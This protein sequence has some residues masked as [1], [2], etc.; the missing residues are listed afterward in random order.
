M[1]DSIFKQ[2]SFLRSPFDVCFLTKI[3]VIFISGYIIGCKIHAINVKR[4]GVLGIGGQVQSIKIL[5]RKE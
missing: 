5:S 3:T 1:S 2:I 4:V